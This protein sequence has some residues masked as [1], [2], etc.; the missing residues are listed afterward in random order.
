MGGCRAASAYERNGLGRNEFGFDGGN[1]SAF[2]AFFQ[3]E[4]YRLD[5][6]FTHVECALV[7]VHSDETVGGV[8]RHAPPEL[9]RVFERFAAMVET[10]LNAFAHGA[11]DL[12]DG[13]LTQIFENDVNAERQG[14]AGLL[15]PP[16]SEIE[17]QMQPLIFPQ[18][19]RFVNDQT[20]IELS[21]ENGLRNLIERHDVNGRLVH[22]Q[23]KL[24][25]GA[26][27]FSGNGDGFVFEIAD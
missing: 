16:R 1:D 22:D 12:L 20:D 2:G 4:F 14:Q 26:C 3:K 6:V 21:A 19:L 10:G 15:V 11:V 13:V 25:I 18:Q 23:A 17:N 27:E 5:A 7:H 24:Q 9:N 8:Y